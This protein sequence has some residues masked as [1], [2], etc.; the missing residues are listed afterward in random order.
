[1]QR[2]RMKTQ[3][4]QTRD[5]FTLTEWL[6]SKALQRRWVFKPLKWK[7][8]STWSLL[9]T[10]QSSNWKAVENT[11]KQPVRNQRLAQTGEREAIRTQSRHLYHQ[12][13]S[14]S[15]FVCPS[16]VKRHKRQQEKHPLTRLRSHLWNAR[17]ASYTNL[18]SWTLQLDRSTMVSRIK[19][20]VLCLSQ[21]PRALQ[22]NFCLFFPPVSEREDLFDWI[23]RK[24]RQR[25]TLRGFDR[26]MRGQSPS[27]HWNNAVL[28]CLLFLSNWLLPRRLFLATFPPLLHLKRKRHQ[29][30][31]RG[32]PGCPSST[33]PR[34]STHIW[35][36]IAF[37]SAHFS[38]SVF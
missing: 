9:R 18:N 22:M 24:R 14:F 27:W 38:L 1:M 35:S 32:A 17:D 21:V 23:S 6:I 20:V 30:N 5:C 4:G 29:S 10:L 31:V 34:S 26:Q 13:H 33:F 2:L 25:F 8:H 15:S 28:F 16:Y 3:P 19:E 36:K 7:D 37:W 11:R 12:Q